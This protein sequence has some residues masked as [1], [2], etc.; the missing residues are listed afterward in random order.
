MAREILAV[1]PA[2]SVL[3]VDDAA[4]FMPIPASAV[5]AERR[6]FLKAF[7]FLLAVSTRGS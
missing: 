6:S 2:I 4:Q 1:V 5:L 3:D 7:T